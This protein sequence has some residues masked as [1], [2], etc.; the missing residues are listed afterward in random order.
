MIYTN[1]L[2]FVLRSD[3]INEATDKSYRQYFCGNLSRPQILSHIQTEDLEIGTSNYHTF[4]SDAPHYHTETSDMI[5]VLDGEY[6]IMIVNTKEVVI[7]KA[8]DFI[9]IPVNCPYAS[10]AKANTRTL[11]V[12]RTKCYDKV[13]VEVDEYLNKWL[14][15]EI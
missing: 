10:K 6:H 7:L 13:V 4:T 3:E 8:G 1:D 14:S 5:Y 11:F 9:S 12:K 2:V 15:T